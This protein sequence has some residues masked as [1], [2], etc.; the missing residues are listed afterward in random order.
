MTDPNQPS[1]GAPTEPPPSYE[2]VQNMSGGAV[3]SYPTQ[4]DVYPNQPVGP[5]MPQMSYPNQYDFK[6]DQYGG[7]PQYPMQQNYGQTAYPMQQGMQYPYGGAPAGPY[8]PATGGQAMYNPQ[9]GVTVQPML[10][11]NQFA[12]RRKIISIVFGFVTLM[13]FIYILVRVIT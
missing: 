3:P 13:V 5:G 7:A 11:N 10:T 6:Y 1:A 12:R 9:G 4:N 2:E 8:P